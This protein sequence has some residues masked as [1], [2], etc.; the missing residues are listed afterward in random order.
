LLFGSRA[1]GDYDLESDFDLALIVK[2]L[3]RN[4][5]NSI[6]EMTAEIEFKY[7]FPVSLL[8][9]SEDTFNHLKE[10]ERRIALDIEREGIPV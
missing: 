1:R 7:D 6:L 9:F 5:R 10:K 4:L 3:N 2:N 8:I